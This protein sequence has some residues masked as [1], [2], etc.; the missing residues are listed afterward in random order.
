MA[1][2]VTGGAGY[3]GSHTCVELLNAGKEVVVVDN[4]Y[5][6]KEE[7]LRRV[8]KITGKPVK[9]Y[10]CDIRDAEGLEKVFTENEID[11]V[12]HFAGLKAVGESCKIPLD[13]YENNIGGTVTLC[14]VMA[15]M[16]VKNFVFSSSATVYGDSPIPYQ[17]DMHVGHCTNPYGRTKYMIEEIL[18]DLYASDNDWS[19]ALLRYFNPIGAHESGHRRGFVEGAA[20]GAAVRSGS[21]GGVLRQDLAHRPA[22]LRQHGYHPDGGSGGLL[23]IVRDGHHRQSRGRRAAHGG[24]GPGRRPGGHGLPLHHHHRRCRFPAGL[25]PVCEDDPGSLTI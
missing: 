24:Q 2:L 7:S 6:S 19:I 23:R 21:G 16:N 10:K 12:I 8:E 22:A 1:I 11:C 15:K 4:L 25:L 3:I 20:D 14:Q 5:N 9:F 18:R 17:E 13:Y